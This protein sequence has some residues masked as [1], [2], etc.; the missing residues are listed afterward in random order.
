MNIS[1]STFSLLSQDIQGVLRV[2]YLY[3]NLHKALQE[4]MKEWFT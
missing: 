2:L 3:K 1:P 4:R